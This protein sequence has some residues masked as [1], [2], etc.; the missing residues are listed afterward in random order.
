MPLSFSV[1]QSCTEVL[2]GQH[3]QNFENKKSEKNGSQGHQD[4]PST[5]FGI[6]TPARSVVVIVDVLIDLIHL[7]PIDLVG[8]GIG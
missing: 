7:V 6:H 3:R 5:G 2:A 8:E 4:K 1:C